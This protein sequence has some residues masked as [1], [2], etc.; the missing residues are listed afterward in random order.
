VKRYEKS[1]GGFVVKE[2]IIQLSWKFEE[3]SGRV[4]EIYWGSLMVGKF[5]DRWRVMKFFG[6]EEVRR[7][8]QSSSTA[9]VCRETRSSSMVSKFVDNLQVHSQASSSST[10]SI[11]LMTSLTL[12]TSAVCWLFTVNLPNESAIQIQKHE[13]SLSN[14]ARKLSQTKAHLPNVNL[15][16][17]TENSSI[18]NKKAS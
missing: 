11:F 14:P 4:A 3:F 5:V 2:N 7:Q 9:K 8:L 17:H 16:L 6:S 18:Q 13:E 12:S 1:L 15:L 10:E